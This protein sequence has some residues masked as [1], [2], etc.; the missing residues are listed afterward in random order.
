M[1]SFHSM[2][3]ENM[4]VNRIEVGDESNQIIMKMLLNHPSIISSQLIS[5]TTHVSNNMRAF[6]SQTKK[7]NGCPSFNTFAQ[8]FSI[9]LSLKS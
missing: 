7:V 1:A 8:E 3:S 2:G 4:L 9:K 6:L 5:I